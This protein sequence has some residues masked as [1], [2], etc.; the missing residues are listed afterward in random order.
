MHRRCIWYIT[1]GLQILPFTKMLIL[2]SVTVCTK[3][4]QAPDIDQNGWDNIT[5]RKWSEKSSLC[6]KWCSL[7]PERMCKAKS[8]SQASQYLLLILTV[9][10]V[11]FLN[12]HPV[13]CYT[14]M[15]KTSHLRGGLLTHANPDVHDLIYS[16]SFYKHIIPKHG[17]HLET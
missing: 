4:A 14:D 12:T 9:A 13:L 2:W 6:C 11:I 3:L 5:N 1:V 16:S 7:K 8:L 17:V 10:I 15:K